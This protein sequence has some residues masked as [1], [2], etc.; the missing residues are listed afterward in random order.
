MS[1]GEAAAATKPSLEGL[2]IDRGPG[3]RRR[4]RGWIGWVVVLVLLVAV[5]GALLGPL[6]D[7]VFPVRVMT[8]PCTRV[9]ATQ[10]SV[11]TTAT[12]YV[13]A[14][15]RAAISSRLSGRL[16]VLHVDVGDH[17][18]EGQLLG[19]LGQADLRAAVA[20]AE[21]GLERARLEIPVLERRVDVSEAAVRTA[22]R[23]LVE[24]SA[25]VETSRERVTEAER[26]VAIEERLLPDGGS[27]EDTVAAARADRDVRTRELAVARASVAAA[28]AEIEQGRAESGVLRA[29]INTARETARQAE[30]TLARAEALRADADIR[31]P[32]AGIVLRKEAEIGEMVSPV[33]ASG[34]TTRGAIVTLAD[35]ASLEMEVD[36]IERD[37]AKVA[38]GL[39][40]RIVLDSRKGPYAG[41]V[42]QIVPTA[43]RTRGTVQVKI[44]F[45][46]L[47]A[48]VLPEMSGRVEFVDED[49]A[50]KVLGADRVLVREASVVRSGD[51]TAV[52]V[53]TDDT[54]ERVVIELADAPPDDG[55]R[56]VSAGLRG[57]EEVV[58][59]PP[60]TLSD[61]ATVKPEPFDE[62]SE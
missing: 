17:V 20:E 49:A 57:G 13:V 7:S 1:D 5:A 21:A 51:S 60:A 18:E 62:E 56:E 23:R 31:A 4:R 14:R 42:R 43:D 34:S 47:D 27:S 8:A 2:R 46:A 3:V 32:F 35:F 55:R 9:A 50:D 40:C 37:I 30:A 39:P 54:V 26:I 12:G 11:R 33:N 10:G 58:I 41:R 16:E 25:V 61:G 45:D 38:E 24:A 48:H 15:K 59:D 6:R 22:E 19:T 53:V 28:Q 36:V 52:W 29:Q 44:A